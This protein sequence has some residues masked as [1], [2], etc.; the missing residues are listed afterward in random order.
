MGRGAL[1]H[2]LRNRVYV[3]DITHRGRAYPGR[4]QAI[5]SDELFTSVQTALDDAAATNGAKSASGASLT[6]MIFDATGEVMSPTSTKGRTGLKRRYYVSTSLVKGKAAA[7]DGVVRRVPGEDV[8]RLVDEKVQHLPQ[9]RLVKV[10]VQDQ[11]IH[12]LLAIDSE[13]RPY[14]TIDDAARDARDSIEVGDRLLIEDEQLRLIVPTRFQR[15]GGRTVLLKPTG[16]AAVGHTAAPKLA[17]A[18]RQGHKIL[19]RSGLNLRGDQGC[20]IAAPADSYERQL[21]EVAFLAP[22]I[23]LAILKGETPPGLTLDAIKRGAPL[24]WADQR[25]VFGF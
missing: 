21:A 12:L 3:G 15:R 16:Q 1:F 18:L 22:D 19:G 2:L 17:R 24:A 9:L 23:Q 7:L 20:E 10:E 5:I 14:L 8:D 11:A 6:G 25:R 4:H 13:R